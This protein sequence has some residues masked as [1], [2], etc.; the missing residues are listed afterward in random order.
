MCGWYDAPWTST[1]DRPFDKSAIIAVFA[2]N[3]DKFHGRRLSLAS[4]SALNCT[5]SKTHTPFYG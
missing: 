4:P 3:V 1:G 5:A 2:A